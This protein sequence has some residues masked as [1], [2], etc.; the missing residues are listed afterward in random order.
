MPFPRYGPSRAGPS[1]PMH[2]LQ[3]AALTGCHRL[4][5]HLFRSSSTGNAGSRRVRPAAL[6]KEEHTEADW[7]PLRQPLSQLAESSSRDGD[8]S[9][10]SQQQDPDIDEHGV[11]RVT[12]EVDGPKGKEPTRFGDWEQRGRVSDF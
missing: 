2:H 5:R 10:R 8:G 6:A 1:L 3:R 9:G 7:G 11:N 4:G 12:G